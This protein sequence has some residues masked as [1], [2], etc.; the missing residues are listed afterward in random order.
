MTGD[1]ERAVSLALAEDLGEAGD[2]TSQA[3][4]NADDMGGAA[5][6]TREACIVSG[7]A[8]GREVCRQLDPQLTWLPLVE[9]GQALK[10]GAQV[11]RLDGR[12]ISILSAER[13]VLNFLCLL[14]GVATLTG[15]FT[16]AVA[17]LPVRI[18]ATRKT[19]PGLRLLQK[20]AV[21]HGGGET[22]RFGLY[23]AVLIKDNHIAAA[24]GVTS[25]VEAVRRS[26]GAAV[27]IEVEADAISQMTEA[28]EAGVDRVLLD[29]MEPGAIRD[30]VN[31]ADGRVTVEVSGGINLENVRACAEAGPDVISIGSLTHSAP[32]IDMS[33]EMDA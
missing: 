31:A 16:N 12:V 20:Q 4:F 26:L 8:A 1:I 11:A 29:N 7:L 14:S 25:A 17:G 23:D 5:I 33:L 10:P 24:G 27:T 21:V 18:A 6:F 13:A 15:R 3:I 32:G 22:H 2:I 28:I 30:C 19:T 9:D